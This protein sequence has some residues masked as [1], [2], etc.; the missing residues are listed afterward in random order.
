MIKM[1]LL[2][3]KENL[4]LVDIANNLNLTKQQVR[5]WL[6][7]DRLIPDKYLPE[8]SRILKVNEREL[9]RI[10]SIEEE[11]QFYEIFVSEKLN[12]KVKIIFEE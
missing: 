3:K 8:L 1:E 2:M 4:Q 5:S 7:H 6:N 12:R 9:N 10:C 11:L